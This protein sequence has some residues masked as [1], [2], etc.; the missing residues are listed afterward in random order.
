MKNLANFEK[1]QFSANIGSG[2]RSR[3]SGGR[4]VG[5]SGSGGGSDNGSGCSSRS[6]VEMT[7]MVGTYIL[8]HVI[9]LVQQLFTC[10]IIQLFLSSQFLH[11]FNSQF[12]LYSTFE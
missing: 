6:D 3:G 5:N 10:R 11:T 2:Y 12:F 9:S 7:M 4:S 8:T 1:L